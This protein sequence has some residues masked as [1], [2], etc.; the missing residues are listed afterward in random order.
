MTAP[1]RDF[2]SPKQ[3]APAIGL[4]VDT[5][6]RKCR[7]GLILVMPL[8]P[9]WRIPPEEANRLISPI[10]HDRNSTTPKNGNAAFSAIDRDAARTVGTRDRQ[11]QRRK[12]R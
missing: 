8:G 4:S 2:V 9:P 10:S 6:Q 1:F 3:L 11:N 7:L 12:R 5:V